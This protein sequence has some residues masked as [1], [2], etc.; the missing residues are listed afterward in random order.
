M[1]FNTR[2]IV[3]RAVDGI[4][5]AI[6]PLNA[7]QQ[8][9]VLD[10]L[11]CITDTKSIVKVAHCAMDYGLEAVA[12]LIDEDGNQVAVRRIDGALDESFTFGLP[13]LTLQK[14]ITEIVNAGNL[15]EHYAK[16]S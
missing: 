9:E 2:K 1:I 6:K 16:K 8:A 3:T 15:E 11:N 7:M 14:I 4:D 13:V 12:G 10:L 5:I